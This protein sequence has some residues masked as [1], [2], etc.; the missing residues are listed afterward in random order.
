MSDV[1]EPGGPA[2]T[3]VDR[4]ASMPSSEEGASIPVSPE[5]RPSEMDAIDREVAE[6][7]G[8]MDP[9][10]MAE[11]CGEVASGDPG[12]S[13][14]SVEPGSKLTGTVV[15][16]SENEVYLEFGPKTQG[17]VSK[18]QFGKKEVLDRGRRVDVTVERYDPEADLLIVNREGAPQRAT[19]SNLS[20]GAIVEGRV[21]GMNKGGLELDLKGIR[22]FMPASQAD[23]IPMKDISVFLNETLRCEVIELDRRSRNV[24]VSRRKI[25]EREA[26]EVKE[27]LKAE[28]AEGQV[29][30]GIVG[31]ITEYGAFIDLGGIDGLAHIRD[32]SWG[33]I[34][35]VADVLTPG[36]EVEVKILRIDHER[37]RIS[38]GVKQCQPDPWATVAEKYPE[39]TA[40]KV[41]VMRLAGFGAFAELELGV[42]G[43]IPI[44]EMSWSRVNTPSDVVSAG[45]MVDAVVIRFEPQKRRI[46]LS[47]KRAQKDP[48]EGVLETFEERSLV[49]GRVT[50]LAD[51][52]VF[53]E[54]VPGV[55]GLIHISELADRRVKSCAEVV[56]AGQEVEARVLGVDLEN[57]RISLSIKA[58]TT[59]VESETG[60]REEA[61]PKIAKKRKKPLRGGLA[62][63]FDW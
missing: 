29:R 26:A 17:V 40:L 45:D 33:T 56:Q 18:S 21:T 6:A 36:E 1:V 35:Q 13:S 39:G 58:V 25:L 5:P 22:A 9:Q 3:P 12:G 2:E 8:S 32:L 53:V 63:H 42:E 34:D 57:R 14:D 62:S 49:Q 60:V 37:E 7:M 30:K 31:T 15:G 41:R 16:V 44:S 10:D 51:F 4:S 47:M 52:G 11:L 43:L 48:W 27:K 20:V 54:L 55:E 59:P 24:L 46:A 28:L 38:L 19:W 23:V 50:R 61:P